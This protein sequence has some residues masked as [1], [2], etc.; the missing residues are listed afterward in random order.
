MQKLSI[1]IIIAIISLSNTHKTTVSNQEIETLTK[2][3]LLN[4]SETNEKVWIYVW[5]S[6]CKP[7]IEKLP[8]LVELSK[9]K[10]LTIYFISIEPDGSKCHSLLIQNG[11]KGKSYILETKYFKH[12]KVDKVQYK[13]KKLFGV[14]DDPNYGI[15]Q[16]YLFQNGK[17]VKY[18]VGE[19]NFE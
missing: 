11:F 14:E 17:F 8:D 18:K 2:K 6:W 15:P 7:C 19:V 3:E 13:L 16:N 4:L 12:K 5:A 1:L 9:Q 10:D